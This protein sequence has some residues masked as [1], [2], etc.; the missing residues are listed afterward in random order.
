MPNRFLLAV[1]SSCVLS[2]AAL[3]A[4][5]PGVDLANLEGWDIVVAADAIPSEKHAAEELR[6][7]LAL[8]TGRTLPIVNSTSRADRHFIVG[9]GEEAGKRGLAAEKLGPEDLRIVVGEGNIA[10]AGGRPRGRLYGVYTFLED[11]LG[12]R[13]LTADHTYVPKLAARVI[14]P[15]DRTYR[16]PLEMRWAYYG[17][18]NRNPALVAR[19]RVY[20]VGNEP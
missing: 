9:P 8:A 5:A 13:F 19:L 1:L 2:A 10:I 14:G 15:V 18:V 17:E 11:Y 6:D 4:E 12:V 16:P 7:H 3:A 20:T